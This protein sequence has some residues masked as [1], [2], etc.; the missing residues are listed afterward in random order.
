[1]EPSDF[2]ILYNERKHVET[3]FAQ[4]VEV[5]SVRAYSCL[6]V[7]CLMQTSLCFQA[8]TQSGSLQETCISPELFCCSPASSVR[9]CCVWCF[10]LAQHQRCS[11]DCP[12]LL[13]SHFVFSLWS[14]DPGLIRL[15]ANATIWGEK[16]QCKLVLTAH[17]CFI[18]AFYLF[19]HK[20]LM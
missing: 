14:R 11:C 20:L 1:M 12:S 6:S 10:L 16:L 9:W 17:L 2:K 13:E 19:T 15:K 4:C 5:G 18:Q 8:G 7:C 3:S